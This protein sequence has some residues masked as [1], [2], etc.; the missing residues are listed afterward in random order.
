MWGKKDSQTWS[1]AAALADSAWRLLWC[2]QA[3]YEARHSSAGHHSRPSK[4]LCHGRPCLHQIYSL[5][6][7]PKASTV[8]V[9][10]LFVYELVFIPACC[11]WLT[12]SFVCNRDHTS[13]NL[14]FAKLEWP[15]A[16]AWECAIEYFA[17]MSIEPCWAYILRDGRTILYIYTYDCTVQT[18]LIGACSGSSQISRGS[19]THRNHF[20]TFLLGHCLIADNRWGGYTVNLDIFVTKF[21]N[22]ENIS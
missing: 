12:V 11:C 7:V 6:G 14:Q 1:W 3:L 8:M 9:P 2:T 18:R 16:Q 21:C 20:R 10:F 22:V 5:N 19:G 17:L 4:D 13:V 15:M